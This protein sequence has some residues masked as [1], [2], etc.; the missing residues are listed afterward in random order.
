MLSCVESY[1]SKIEKYRHVLVVKDHLLRSLAT[2]KKI[3]KVKTGIKKHLVT[4]LPTT[5]AVHTQT[6]GITSFVK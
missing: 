1:D 5:V 2:N 4:K 6:S 3:Q